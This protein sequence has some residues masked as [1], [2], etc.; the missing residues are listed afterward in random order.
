MVYSDAHAL[1]CYYRTCAHL[2]LRFSMDVEDCAALSASI[3]NNWLGKLLSAVIQSNWL[4]FLP[5]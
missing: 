4:G 2:G 3:V 1:M 5:F